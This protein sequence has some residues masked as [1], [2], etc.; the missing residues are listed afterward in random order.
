MRT[1][2][3]WSTGKDAAW[4]LH[5]LRQTPGVEVVGLLSTVNEAFDRVA[6]HGVRRRLLEAQAAAAGL[7]LEVINIPWP[8][9]NEV[10]EARM[11]EFVVRQQ[12]AGIE[13]I[14]FGDLY[15]EDIRAYREQR[16]AET[17]IKPLFPL[18]G[19]DTRELAREMIAGGMAAYLACV[20]PRKMPAEF[21][22]RTFDLRLLEELPAGVDPCGENGEFH[23]CVVG[24]PMFSAPIAVARGDV[25]ERDGFVYA[26]IVPVA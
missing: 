9:S 24:G 17:G 6:M 15:L 20:D 19:R 4:S 5:V 22:G 3:S 8:C 2:L 11:G 23:T 1:L 12:A 21:A 18:W 14:A 10:Y 25:V 26:D 16:L 7:P 13:A